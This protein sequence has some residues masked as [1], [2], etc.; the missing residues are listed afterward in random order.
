LDNLDKSR[1]RGRPR[2]YSSPEEM[3]QIINDYFRECESKGEPK[4]IYGLALALDLT[5]EGLMGYSTRDEY[6]GLVKR[7]KEEIIREV[8]ARGH[9]SKGNPAFAI[10]WLKNVA[11]WAD[12]SEVEMTNRVTLSVPDDVEDTGDNSDHEL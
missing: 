8:E 9:T 3:E 7:A 12:K 11:K 5:Y 10:F 6:A 2:K 4:T 1:S